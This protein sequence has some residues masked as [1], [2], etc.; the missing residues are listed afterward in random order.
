MFAISLQVFCGPYLY[1]K[2]FTADIRLSFDEIGEI[3]DK[4]LYLS[5]KMVVKTVK[6]HSEIIT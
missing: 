4:G 5:P 1:L 3:L 2:A 6:Y